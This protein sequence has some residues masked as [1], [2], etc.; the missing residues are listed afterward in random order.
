[1]LITGICHLSY[2]E[3]L[4]RRRLQADLITAFKLFT[5]RFDIDPNLFFLPPTRRGLRE[6][7]YKVLQGTPPK[8]RVGSFGEDCEI[9]E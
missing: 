5:G 6:H 2:E 8:E 7:P 1:M 3:K 9:L 4:Q